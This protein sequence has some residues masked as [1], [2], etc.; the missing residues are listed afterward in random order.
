[1]H[2]PPGTEIEG[3]YKITSILGSG[4]MGSVYAARQDD[5]QRQ[6]AIK[7]LHSLSFGETSSR[8]RFDRE[9]RLLSALDHEHLVKLYAIGFY[10]ETIP[11]LVT[12]FI[13]GKTL[14]AE[15]SLSK[16][17]IERAIDIIVQVCQALE[18]VHNKDI[19]HRDL[20]PHNI[21]LESG[22]NMDHAKVLD[23]GV[24]KA[25]AAESGDTITKTGEIIGTAHYLSPEQ[26]AGSK[27]IDRRSDIYSLACVLYECVCAQP[28]FTG[29]SAANLIYQHCNEEPRPPSERA[30]DA[31]LRVLD[32]I[33]HKALKKDPAERYQS[34]AEF[35]QALLSVQQGFTGKIQ[36]HVFGQRAKPPVYAAAISLLVIFAVCI[37]LLQQLS[38]R[39]Q[40]ASNQIQEGSMGPSSSPS[41]FYFEK[42]NKML[43][44][45]ET[46]SERN[47]RV[48][49]AKLLR[50]MHL[51]TQGIQRAKPDDNS[52]SEQISVIDK[53]GKIA[54]EQYEKNGITTELLIAISNSAEIERSKKHRYQE[55]LLQLLKGKADYLSSQ[56]CIPLASVYF[57]EAGATALAKEIYQ[58]FVLV[59][60]K[61]ANP[62]DRKNMGPFVHL[63]NYMLENHGAKQKQIS[64]QLSKIYDEAETLD[65]PYR[66]QLM[67]ELGTIAARDGNLDFAEKCLSQFR[68]KA[69]WTG[70]RAREDALLLLVEVLEKQGRID[71]TLQV[72]ED[73]KEV[74]LRHSNTR[75]ISIADGE[76]NRIKS[77]AGKET[78]LPSSSILL[79]AIDQQR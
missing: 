19:V 31:S 64:Q 36:Q 25:L 16:L 17:S 54:R 59:E 20:K 61:I 67:F 13:D 43:D 63:A 9:A 12:E 49:N 75:I 46:G 18:Y 42:A 62:L 10:A 65:D 45:I 78:L 39:K 14:A 70:D 3:K 5:L 22:H 30:G 60:N 52:V 26:C 1:M 50:T 6:V 72:L 74:G 76:I 48:K 66:F 2:L 71:E 37:P 8:Q 15:L 4:G 40:A 11:Y 77:K 28:P 38:L 24:A 55:G 57:S 68:T 35:E 33:L 29:S 34:M 21:M 23:F 69:R 56:S 79:H 73:L 44:E 7:V 32:K 41:S 58:K 27:K 47:K 53:F 51:I